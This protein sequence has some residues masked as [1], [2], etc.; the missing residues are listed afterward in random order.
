MFKIVANVS[1]FYRKACARFVFKANTVP[2]ENRAKFTVNLGV[3]LNKI[4]AVIAAL[5]KIIVFHST[6]IVPFLGIV[7][8]KNGTILYNFF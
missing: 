1:L 5:I 8:P 2:A 3:M 7:N 6:I 4:Y